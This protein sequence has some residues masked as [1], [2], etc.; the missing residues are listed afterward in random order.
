MGDEPTSA[1]RAVRITGPLALAAMTLGL[2][3]WPIGFN[4]GAYGVVMYDDVFSV[5]VASTILFAI[6]AINR[7]HRPPWNWM[8]LTALAGPLAWLLSASVLV[9]STT[10]AMDRPAFI[11]A[12]VVVGATSVPITLKL[13]VDMFTPELA[14]AESRRLAL[15]IVGLVALIGVIGFTVGRN[16]DRYMVCQDFAIA[17]AYEPDNCA[18]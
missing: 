6:T 14:H 18:R 15:S 13:L 16:N 8:V 3:T 7:S 9:G 5:V 10:E 2:V 17:G 1:P 4:L 12:L 11:V